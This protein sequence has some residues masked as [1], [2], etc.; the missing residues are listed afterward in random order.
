V[1]RHVADFFLFMCSGQRQI[2][3][4]WAKI[5]GLNSSCEYW[6]HIRKAALAVVFLLASTAHLSAQTPVTIWPSSAVP[7]AIDA[8]PDSAVELGVRFT[9]DTNGTIRCL[10][11]SFLT[12]ARSEVSIYPPSGHFRRCALRLI[13]LRGPGLHT[14]GHTGATH[15]LAEHSDACHTRRWFR[16]TG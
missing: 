6:K 16:F 15:D 7:G 3:S 5:P 4:V 14:V 9:A 2:S 12:T 11:G 8:S 1:V 13:L 10:Y